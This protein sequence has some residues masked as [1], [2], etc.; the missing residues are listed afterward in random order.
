VRS[1]ILENELSSDLT[2]EQD[3]VS[4]EKASRGEWKKKQEKRV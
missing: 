1:Q 3:V 2:K 4:F